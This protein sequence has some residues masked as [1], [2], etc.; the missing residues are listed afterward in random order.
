MNIVS[1]IVVWIWLGSL[2]AFV[3]FLIKSLLIS[4]AGNK[5]EGKALMKKGWIALLIN[6]ICFVVGGATGSSSTSSN[7]TGAVVP[8]AVTAQAITPTPTA[9][10]SVVTATPASDDGNTSQND[11]AAS[12]QEELS[13]VGEV[14][15]DTTLSDNFGQNYE[16]TRDG[17][18]Y[19]I[20]VWA[21]DIAY[22][23]VLAKQ[24]NT[25]MLDQWNN[26]VSTINS[27]CSK[28]VDSLKKLGIEDPV[29]S[30][31]VLNDQNH[32]NTLFTSVNGVTFYDS[33]NAQ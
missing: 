19:T 18:S 30:W 3:V 20:F 5:V 8:P 21:D 1:I 4:K 13:A 6:A 15:L 10:E 31:S 17:S 12:D 32:E 23:S 28:C 33:V 25:E 24:G 26:M 14:L 16:L 22:A 2:I 29:I 11:S 27:T 7:N 9:S